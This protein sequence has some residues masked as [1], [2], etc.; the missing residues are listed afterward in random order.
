VAKAGENS[1]QDGENESQPPQTKKKD[2]QGGVIGWT[3]GKEEKLL[4][5]RKGRRLSGMG[6]LE[7]FKQRTAFES[8]A[9]QLRGRVNN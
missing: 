1:L 7:S 9:R 6:K 8:W 5:A 4:G 3:F 2:A